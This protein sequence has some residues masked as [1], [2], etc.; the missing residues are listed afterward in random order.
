MKKEAT[1][2]M[3]TGGGR[4]ELKGVAG[5][6]QEAEHKISRSQGWRVLCAAR[7]PNY[8]CGCPLRTGRHAIK[9]FT[10][11]HQSYQRKCRYI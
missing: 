4:D 1:A 11:V 7:R 6:Q 8:F 10:T 3:T 5:R 2:A 9:Y